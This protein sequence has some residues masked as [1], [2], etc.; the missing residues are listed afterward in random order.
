MGKKAKLENTPVRK[1]KSK[2]FKR[3]KEEKKEAFEVVA[4]DDDV[5]RSVCSQDNCLF[6]SFMHTELTSHSE[7]YEAL[8]CHLE[9]VISVVAHIHRHSQT[10]H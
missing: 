6:A 5:M 7:N 9:Q 10:S 4:E 1:E 3:G 8:H 2:R